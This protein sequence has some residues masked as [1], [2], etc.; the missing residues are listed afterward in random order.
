MQLPA[1][2]LIWVTGSSGSNPDLSAIHKLLQDNNLQQFFIFSVDDFKK[3]GEPFGD[4]R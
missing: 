4:G 1:K 3:V 2:Q